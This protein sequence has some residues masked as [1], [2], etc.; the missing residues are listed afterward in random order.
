M[1]EG[2]LAGVLQEKLGNYLEL[3]KEQLRMG[4]WNGDLILRNIQLKPVEIPD[5]P[6]Q[7]IGG[8]LRKLTIHIP[9]QAL[10]SKSAVLTM[11]ELVVVVSSRGANTEEDREEARQRM[12]AEKRQLYVPSAPSAPP[13]PPRPRPLAHT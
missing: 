5:W 3:S 8:R 10:S 12:L 2:W 9:W 6:F 4:L 1:L 7:V 13:R 11:D